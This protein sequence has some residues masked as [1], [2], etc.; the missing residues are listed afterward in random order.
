MDAQIAAVAYFCGSGMAAHG[1]GLEP[2]WLARI[3][4]AGP[5]R[6]SEW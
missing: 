2:E 4:A 1:C 5:L 3:R 6:T